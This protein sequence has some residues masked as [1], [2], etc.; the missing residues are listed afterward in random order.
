MEN[1]KSKPSRI[2]SIDYGQA[3]IGLAISDE[4][5][6]IA[7]PLITLTAEKRSEKTA[8]KLIRWLLDYQEQHRFVTQEI[9]IGMPL[10]M[11]GKSGLLA[12]EVRHF[13]TLLQQQTTIPIKTWDE[14]LTTVQ[15]DR[16][17]RE[18][19]LTRR[20]RAKTVDTVSAT[21]LLQSYL[22]FLGMQKDLRE[23]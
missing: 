20:Q 19:H 1:A 21:I 14:R 6:L 8:E 3:R 13:V 15:A 10:L 7:S 2:V 18:G 5:H 22:D 17:L 4:T 23:S 11:S 16:S 12:D 9:I